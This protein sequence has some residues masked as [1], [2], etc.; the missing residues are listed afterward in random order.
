MGS[1]ADPLRPTG[2]DG[3]MGSIASIFPG[4][5]GLLG[6]YRSRRGF[7]ARTDDAETSQRDLDKAFGWARSNRAALIDRGNLDAAN[8]WASV[9]SPVLTSGD[10]ARLG[11]SADISPSYVGGGT[12]QDLGGA[13]AT[14]GRDIGLYNL[15]QRMLAQGE[16]RK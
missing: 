14:L 12:S 9:S 7:G 15:G 1:P 11:V 8:R 16:S 3:G 2:R 5:S 4:V 13:Y 10:L 6:V